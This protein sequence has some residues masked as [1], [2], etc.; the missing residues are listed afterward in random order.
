MAPSAILHSVVSK[1]RKHSLEKY[2]HFKDENNE[3][4]RR[5]TLGLSKGSYKPSMEA[6]LSQPLVH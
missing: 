5:R 2:A 6:Q 4:Q 1:I 3:I